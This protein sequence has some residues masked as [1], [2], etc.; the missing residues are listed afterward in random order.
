M[1]KDNETQDD[2]EITENSYIDT[3]LKE[4]QKYIERVNEYESKVEHLQQ[5]L[6]S[7]TEQFRTSENCVQHYQSELLSHQ[8]LYTYTEHQYSDLSSKVNELEMTCEDL[9]AKVTYQRR[10]AEK[11]RAHKDII[12]DCS[13]KFNY[14]VRDMMTEEGRQT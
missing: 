13:S 4:N 5:Q 6:Y 2:H 12:Q 3:I 14:I 7:I 9:R 8:L 1:I 10:F 11:F